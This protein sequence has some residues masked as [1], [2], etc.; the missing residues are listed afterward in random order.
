M[1]ARLA[2]NRHVKVKMKGIEVSGANLKDIEK[3]LKVQ[4]DKG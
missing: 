2:A 1:K 3:F 4:Q